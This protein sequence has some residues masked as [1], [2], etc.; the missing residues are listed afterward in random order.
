MAERSG[1]PDRTPVLV[2]VGKITD[3]ATPETGLSPLELMERAAR[4]AA[5]DAGPAEA[6]LDAIDVV[7]TSGLTVD[8][9]I[10]GLEGLRTYKNAPLTLCRRLGVA[11]RQIVTNPVGGDTPQK[12]V[13]HY[14]AEIAAGRAEAALLAGGEALKTMMGRLA[15]GL[16]L[17]AWREDPDAAPPQLLASPRPPATPHEVAHG[18]QYPANVYPLFENALRRKHGWTLNEHAGAMGALFARF[19]AVAA[20]HPDAWYPTAR[21]AE[22]LATPSPQNR[23][24]AFPYP[25]YLNAVIQVNMAAAVILTTRD[26]ARALG[27]PEEK[28][29]YL[30]G[31][32]DATDVWHV[33]ERADFHSAPGFRLAAEEALRMADISV[34]RI[35]L[36]DL[37]SCFPC[38]V[39]IALDTLGLAPDDPR[40]LT[41]TGGLPYF[42]GPGN[43]YT[44]HGIVSM[45]ERLRARPGA[46]G[47]VNGNGWFLTKHAVGVYATAPQGGPAPFA[48]AAW[49][50]RAPADYAEDL[51]KGD[52]PPFT[53][54]PEGAGRVETYTVIF[55]RTGPTR[56]VVVGRL[57]S[58]ARFLA[59][60][61]ND[62]DLLEKICAAD[63]LDAT[64][65][66]APAAEPGGVNRFTPAP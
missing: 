27:V 60:T 2:G 43:N 9:D 10:A 11:P 33:T 63:F 5:A 8:E 45:A 46:V 12:L 64:G 66:A 51:A 7:A 59:E 1:G 56:G 28:L 65:Q 35:D 15:A 19:A 24:V 20:E 44:M 37:Y 13:N 49:A 14:A 39:R 17:E 38:A 52:A 36:F 22:E 55:D 16:D 41:V 30:L 29:V 40:P 21:S 61:P 34:D 3:R 42:G 58:G 48:D 32:G 4:R 47:F 31:C 26:R 6:L 53:E 57:E 54:R 62:R 18:I 25:K 23:M 50:R